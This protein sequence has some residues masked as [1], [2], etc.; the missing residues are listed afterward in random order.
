MKCNAP[1]DYENKLKAIFNSGVTI[2]NDYDEF[3]DY[4][5]TNGNGISF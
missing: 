5:N 1:A 2:W 3:G 4:S